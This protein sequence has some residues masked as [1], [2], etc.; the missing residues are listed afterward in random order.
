MSWSKR[1]GDYLF[2][3]E[4]ENVLVKFV[5]LIILNVNLSENSTRISSAI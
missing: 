3:L 5:L 1:A 4:Q 2:C